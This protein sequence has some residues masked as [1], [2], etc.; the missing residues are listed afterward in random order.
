MNVFLSD[1]DDEITEIVKG[2]NGCREKQNKIVDQ[3]MPDLIK[4]GEAQVGAKCM[5]LLC[6]MLRQ[7]SEDY[8]VINC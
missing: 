4:Q 1:D 2:L 5:F 8:V 3:I 7:T 6:H